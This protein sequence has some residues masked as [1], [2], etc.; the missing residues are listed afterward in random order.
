MR[1]LLLHFSASL[2]KVKITSSDERAN[3]ELAAAT[4]QAGALSLLVD[5]HAQ[6][7]ENEVAC[8]TF[9]HFKAIIL[10]YAHFIIV[11]TRIFLNG[12]A[13]HTDVDILRTTAAVV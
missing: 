12:I 6:L 4:V 3:T 9:R 8:A 2:Q 7:G 11:A 1:I 10:I 5:Q 13:R